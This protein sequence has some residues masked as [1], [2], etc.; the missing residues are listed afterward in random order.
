MD[1][2]KVITF[3]YDDDIRSFSIKDS[4]DEKK[5]LNTIIY[6]LN[7]SVINEIELNCD[8]IKEILKD[9]AEELEKSIVEY[10]NIIN[11]KDISKEYLIPV[12]INEIYKEPVNTFDELTSIS[13]N[14]EEWFLIPLIVLMSS[15][16]LEGNTVTK[17]IKLIIALIALVVLGR[18]IIKTSK[19]I[20]LCVGKVKRDFN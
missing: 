13:D 18:N 14:D 9:V 16:F 17:T 4:Y 8:D 11:L 15:D 7:Y 6:C 10:W 1:E 19:K 20:R 3:K 2:N 5:V 12:D